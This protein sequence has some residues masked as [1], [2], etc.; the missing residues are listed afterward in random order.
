MR[1]PDSLMW[2]PTLGLEQPLTCWY[3]MTSNLERLLD[4][5]TLDCLKTGDPISLSI[6]TPPRV[7]SVNRCFCDPTPPDLMTSSVNT[8]SLTRP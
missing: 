3:Q 8:T 1:E 6:S 5:K 2:V 7:V 4:G